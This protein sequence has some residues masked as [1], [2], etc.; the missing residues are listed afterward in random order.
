MYSSHWTCIVRLTVT[1]SL[2]LLLGVTVCGKSWQEISPLKTTRAEVLQMLG[3]PF[4]DPSDKSEYFGLGH[5]IVKLRWTRAKCFEPPSESNAVAL[6]PSDLVI[7]VTVEPKAPLSYGEFEPLKLEAES[8]ANERF[9]EFTVYSTNCL[10]G[11]EAMSCSFTNDK[12]G[13][14]YSTSKMGTTAV[15]YFPTKTEWDNWKASHAACMNAEASP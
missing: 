5:E 15:Y 7:Q 10:G 14:G 9:P 2:L 8:R 3:P 11:R 4:I 6:D 12:T 13:F 1:S